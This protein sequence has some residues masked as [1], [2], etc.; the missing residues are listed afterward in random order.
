M[1]KWRSSEV[2]NLSEP[3]PTTRLSNHRREWHHSLYTTDF[4]SLSW[5]W[6]P[7]FYQVWITSLAKIERKSYVCVWG[8][9]IKDWCPV[10]FWER[11]SSRMSWKGFPCNNKHKV[12]PLFPSRNRIRVPNQRQLIRLDFKWFLQK[13]CWLTLHTTLYSF[14]RLASSF[15][16]CSGK[17]VSKT[18]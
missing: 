1:S 12:S 3:W 16:F 8:S 14:P 9:L 6:R 13:A 7:H 15:S 10:A 18:L 2:H 17:N 5:P 11:D 4:T